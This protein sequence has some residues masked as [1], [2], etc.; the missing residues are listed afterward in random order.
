MTD[1][2]RRLLARRPEALL[3]LDMPGVALAGVGLAPGRTVF[4]THNVE[5]RVWRDV[6]KH[7]PLTQRPFLAVEWRKIAIEERRC[8]SQAD[9]TLAVSELDARTMREAGARSVAVVP[10]GTDPRP[11]MAP[12]PLG[13]GPVRLLFV[14]SGAYW[15]YERGL[16][17]FAREVMPRLG[18]SG[19]VLDV[20]GE[21][22]VKAVRAPGITY[23]GRV[24]DLGEFYAAA[25]A[26]VV[27]VFEGSGTRL[28]LIEAAMLGRPIISTR[29]GAEG[30]PIS[31]GR[32]YLAAES[33]EQWVGA[34]ERIRRGEVEE[35]A[36]RARSA[37]AELTW[38]RIGAQLAERY[39][40]L[41]MTSTR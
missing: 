17:W 35:M 36:A 19:A 26:V 25:H 23:R 41:Q 39:E 1:A 16:A 9:L 7:R 12:A 22:P 34:V 38:P 28:K 33:P 8:W 4:S 31:P 40:Q 21:P 5:H 30:L 18:E 20:V 32:D 24:P 2:L 29:L 27:P 11:A 14:G 3:H 10:N 6:A 37:L 15:P 13:D